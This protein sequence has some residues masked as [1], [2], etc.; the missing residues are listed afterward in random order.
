MEDQDFE[1]DYKQRIMWSDTI[2]RP[3]TVYHQSV[4]NWLNVAGINHNLPG[5]TVSASAQCRLLFIIITTIHSTG[6][7]HHHAIAAICDCVQW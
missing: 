6:I 7:L 4:S 1:S 3:A 2:K 5:F